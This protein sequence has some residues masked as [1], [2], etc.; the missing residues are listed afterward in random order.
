MALGLVRRPL[1]LG[2]SGG[3][4][5]PGP[6]NPVG[7]WRLFIQLPEFEKLHLWDAFSSNPGKQAKNFALEN[8]FPGVSF[9]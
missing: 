3:S 7:I 1:P 2:I 9:K 8:A 5:R 6:R 4:P